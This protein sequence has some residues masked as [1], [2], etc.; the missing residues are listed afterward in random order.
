MLNTPHKV[1]QFYMSAAKENH[2]G[3]EYRLTESLRIKFTL[4]SVT[5]PQISN[6]KFIHKHLVFRCRKWGLHDPC[7]GGSL[8]V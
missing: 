5:E 3:I 4:A 8:T 2:T 7:L 6:D 1:Y